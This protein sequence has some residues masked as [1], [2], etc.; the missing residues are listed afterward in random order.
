M[1]A[2]PPFFFLLFC[3]IT[4]LFSHNYVACIYIPSAYQ[5]RLNLSGTFYNWQYTGNNFT[6]HDT[7]YV[8][9]VWTIINILVAKLTI[10]LLILGVNKELSQHNNWSAYVVI[11][12][13]KYSYLLR[14]YGYRLI[15]IVILHAQKIGNFYPLKL[16]LVLSMLST[17]QRNCWVLYRISLFNKLL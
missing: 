8:F 4:S 10:F 2:H 16:D 12:K 1:I 14:V 13:S 3:L 9:C 11:V 6:N 17:N 15:D 7:S 5:T